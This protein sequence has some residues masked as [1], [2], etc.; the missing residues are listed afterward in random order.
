M[1]I[2][3]TGTL[4]AFLADDLR[5]NDGRPSL[6][7]WVMVYRA[8]L[9][10]DVFFDLRQHKYLVG[11][12]EC[13]SPRMVVYKAGQMGASE[14]GI[15]RALYACDVQQATT[16]YVFPTERGVID[17]SSAR[18]GP[19][20]EVSPYLNG[21]VS[22]ANNASKRGADRMS[23]K[24]VRDRFLYLRHGMV[25]PSGLAPQLKSVDADFLVLDELDEID[26]RAPEI[27]R[28]R[29]GHSKSPMELDIS[30]P[31]YHG[32]GIH[33]EWMQS[34]QREW[35]VPCP[36]CGRKQMM[37][38]DHVVIEWDDLGRPVA[39]YGMEDGR[40]YA[41]C[42]Y[43]GAEL[44]RLADGEWVASEPSRRIA[45]FHLSRLFGAT[46][47]LLAIVNA[48]SSTDETRRRECFNQDLGLP[49]RPRGEQVDEKIL[50][51]CRREYAP[52]AVA[53]EVT[54]MG[55]DVG[56]V[57]HVII[58]GA[59]TQQGDALA[60]PLRYA[61]E[62]ERFEQLN[63]LIKQ[64][65]VQTCVIDAL[66]ETR[67]AR[68]FQAQ[69][70]DGRVWLA[71]YHG[72]QGSKKQEPVAWNGRDGV[73]DVDRTR[74]LDMTLARFVEEENTLPASI[75]NVRDYYAHLQA[76]TRVV[77]ASR[78]GGQVVAHYVETGADHYAHAEN[79]VTVAALKA[80]WWMW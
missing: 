51:N 69:H 9:K 18:I 73:V 11:L 36:A 80:A 67:K 31:T 32:R 5:R 77:D 65:R 71:Y 25:T 28:K 57:L 61:G 55:V 42:E 46:V 39:W 60:R 79:Y 48:L 22:G 58:R 34:D 53:G 43:C 75:R 23:L 74:S 29:L 44:D 8:S 35:F 3:R 27:A 6:L 66:P 37:T 7:T 45:G 38:I 24:R 52:G 13:D 68:E 30:T 59:L 2:S 4:A 26:P 16:L 10:P 15:S 62:V 76:P 54:F 41:A 12:Y 64:Y 40:A 21:I 33:A 14:Y 47:D 70:P 20:L 56:K 17:F 72:G 49:Y 1:P 78:Q 63:T 19:A 50:D